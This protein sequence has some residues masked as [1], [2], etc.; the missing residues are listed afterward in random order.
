MMKCI[1]LLLRYD[2]PFKG[3]HSDAGMARSQLLRPQSFV[4]VQVPDTGFF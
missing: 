1:H 3:L 2:A 4:L